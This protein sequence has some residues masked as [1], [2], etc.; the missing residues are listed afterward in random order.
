MTAFSA[1]LD[2]DT[3]NH[4]GYSQAH[5][6]TGNCIN[7]WF[8]FCGGDSQNQG[9]VTMSKSNDGDSTLVIRFDKCTGGQYQIQSVVFYDVDMRGNLT[10]LPSGRGD[11]LDFAIA[12]DGQRVTIYDRIRIYD[13]PVP[14]DFHYSI[15]VADTAGQNPNLTIVCDPTIHNIGLNWLTG[16]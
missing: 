9:V 3:A 4:N 13:G 8:R 5:D 2:V 6:S 11:Q 16:L 10:E 1:T 14:A 12:C 7:Y 15:R